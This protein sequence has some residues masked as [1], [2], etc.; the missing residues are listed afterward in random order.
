[1]SQPRYTGLSMGIGTITDLTFP[2][3]GRQYYMRI[4]EIRG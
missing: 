3:A 2:T 4:T 1:M